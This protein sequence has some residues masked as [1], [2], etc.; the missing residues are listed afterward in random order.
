MS[1]FEYEYAKCLGKGIGFFKIASPG[2]Q[3]K[4]FHL[5]HISFKSFETKI[6][7]YKVSALLS[8]FSGFIYEVVRAQGSDFKWCSVSNT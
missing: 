6:L 8:R 4:R 3:N 2:D 1:I 5:A 7:V